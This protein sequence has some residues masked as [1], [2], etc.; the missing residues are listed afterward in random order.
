MTHLFNPK[1]SN[2]QSNIIKGAILG[3][4]SLV[5]PKKGKNIYLSMRSK[6]LEWLQWKASE[7][8]S[9]S[10]KGNITNDGTYRWHSMCYPIFSE[11]RTTFYDKDDKRRLLSETLDMLQD[12][13][14][15]V[16]FAD[17]AKVKNKKIILNTH[18]WGE[19]GSKK[20]VKYFKA[21]DIEAN[22]KITSRGTKINFEIENAYKIYNLVTSQ[23]PPFKHKAFNLN[24]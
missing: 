22:L 19:E 1:L 11:L 18:I 16:W 13:A 9:L 4:S 5:R 14:I 20:I 21:I 8:E 17:A 24:S 12:V 7:L 15:S 10:T 2:R 6:D 3:G 23:L